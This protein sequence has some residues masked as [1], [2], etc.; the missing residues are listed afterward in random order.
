MSNSI[1]DFLGEQKCFSRVHCLEPGVESGLSYLEVITIAMIVLGCVLAVIGFLGCCGAMKQVKVFLIIVSDMSG[2]WA[3]AN[4]DVF[5]L[6]RCHN[7]HNY[8]HWSRNS[9]LFR[10]VSLEIRKRNY[11]KTTSDS[12]RQLRRTTWSEAG[13]ESNE[14]SSPFPR[15]GFPHVQCQYNL[16]RPKKSILLNVSFHCSFNVVAWGTD[17]I[18]TLPKYGIEEIHGGIVRWAWMRTS[19]IHWLAVR[20]GTFFQRTGMICLWTS[21]KAL[22]PVRRQA[23]LLTRSYAHFSVSAMGRTFLFVLGVLR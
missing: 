12:A 13:I 17:P 20:L 5:H 10:G 7:Y 22:L 14:T 21:C 3:V 15:L 6:V 9:D 11:T 2:N 23:I 18:S 8:P 19:P 4:G 16:S 1:T